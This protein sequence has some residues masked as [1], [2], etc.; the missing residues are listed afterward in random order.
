MILISFLILFTSSVALTFLYLTVDCAFRLWD[1]LK[2]DFPTE[3]DLSGYAKVFWTRRFPVALFSHVYDRAG[4]Y[5]ISTLLFILTVILSFFCYSLIKPAIWL[6][7]MD[8][9]MAFLSK[10]W[11]YK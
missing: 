11:E 7:F 6:P 5:W 9:L 2:D 8:W 3:E 10:L 1:E 4:T